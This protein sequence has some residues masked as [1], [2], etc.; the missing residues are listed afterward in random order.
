MNQ[1]ELLEYAKKQYTHSIN[2]IRS[3]SAEYA[4][5]DTDAFA[6]FRF[7]EMMGLNP[8]KAVLLRILDKI[9]RVVNIVDKNPQDIKHEGLTDNICD[10]CNY[11]IILAAMVEEEIK[12]KAIKEVE[13]I[14]NAN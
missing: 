7:S 4:K 9:A 10:L 14:K 11:Q 6:N 1:A 13:G 12:N 3:K 8:K 5:P 2:L